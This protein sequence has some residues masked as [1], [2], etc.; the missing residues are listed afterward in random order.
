MFHY[1]GY[2]QEVI[3]GNSKLKAGIYRS[4]EEFKYNNP[5][6][7]FDYNIRTKERGY[8]FLNSEGW[9]QFYKIDMERKETRTIGSV[10]GF[11]DGRNV[12]I[13]EDNPDLQKNTEFAKVEFYGEFCY[14]EG[15]SYSYMTTGAGMGATATT[16]RTE[17]IL[18]INT[19]KVTILSKSLIRKLLAID[20]ELLSEFNKEKKKRKKLKKY[21]IKY[22]ETLDLQQN[23]EK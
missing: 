7:E 4:F 1:Y 17:K 15:V 5:S 18:S 6:L 9:V 23:F 21:F 19:G 3:S 2:G 22:L 10:F 11:C 16:S 14:F 8:G 13:N 12:Y 20:K